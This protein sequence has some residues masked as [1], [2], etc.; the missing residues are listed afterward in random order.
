MGNK[1]VGIFGF[2]TSRLASSRAATLA[3]ALQVVRSEGMEVADGMSLADNRVAL[4]GD[5]ALQKY[6]RRSG[7]GKLSASHGHH[8]QIVYTRLPT[9]GSPVSNKR[10]VLS[11]EIPSS[12]CVE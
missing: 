12:S 6:G 10:S 5:M 4:A 2:K 8:N 7:G 11:R 1:Q 3:M 9:P